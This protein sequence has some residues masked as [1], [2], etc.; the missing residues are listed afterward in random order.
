ML[1]TYSSLVYR[2]STVQKHPRPPRRACPSLHSVCFTFAC[3]KSRRTCSSP[4]NRSVL[5]NVVK[6]SHYRPRQARISPGEFFNNRHQKVIRLPAQRTGRLDSLDD[7]ART[8]F[9]WRLSRPQG[10]IAAGRIK[11]MKNSNDPT[12]NSTCDL[13]A[14]SAVPQPIA[15]IPPFQDMWQLKVKEGMTLKLRN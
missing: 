9:C 11:A 14:F 4:W 5:E 1:K 3:Y 12:E 10:H 15:R 7:I 6:L 13:P 8:R 2:P